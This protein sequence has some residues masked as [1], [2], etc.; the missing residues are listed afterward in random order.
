MRLLAVAAV[1]LIGAVVVA[2][3]AALLQAEATAAARS[4]FGALGVALSQCAA[5]AMVMAATDIVGAT[6]RRRSARLPLAR[7]PQGPITAAA[8]A[9]MLMATGYAPATNPY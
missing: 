8:A 9:T 3:E 6:A 4:Q 7:L 2:T 1:A 5:V